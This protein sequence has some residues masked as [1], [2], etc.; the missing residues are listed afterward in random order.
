ML[1]WILITLL[2]MLPMR[3]VLAIDQSCQMHELGSQQSMGHHMH[4]GHTMPETDHDDA[5]ASDDCCCCESTVSCSYDCGMGTSASVIMQ[6]ALTVPVLNK[7]SFRTQVV[8][9]LVFREL[10][11]LSRPPAYL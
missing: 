2:V 3:A 8:D 10:V 9:N 1:N 6:H 4:S 7:S 11:P 5:V